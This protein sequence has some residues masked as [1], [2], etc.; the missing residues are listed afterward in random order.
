MIAKPAQLRKICTPLA[1]AHY[2]LANT[3]HAYRSFSSLTPF[4]L[5]RK[6]FSN[7]TRTNPSGVGPFP[8]AKACNLPSL[9]GSILL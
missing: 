3:P 2:G 4:W 1:T 9:T 5:W 7:E 6:V 8:V